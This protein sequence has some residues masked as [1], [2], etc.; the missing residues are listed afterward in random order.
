M[1][2]QKKN[3]S[4]EKNLKKLGWF[5]LLY[6]SNNKNVILCSTEKTEETPNIIN[7]AKNKN[8]N[9]FKNFKQK[10]KKY[11]C[12]LTISDLFHYFI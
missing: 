3:D 4:Q 11:R 8:K 2:T 5:S 7:K 6:R 9:I 10:M 12:V 1:S